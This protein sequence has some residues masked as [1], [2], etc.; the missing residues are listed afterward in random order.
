MYLSQLH[1]SPTD[2][3][4]QRTLHDVYLLHQ[5]L[6]AAFP[7]EA[8]QSGGRLLYRLEPSGGT[9]PNVRLLVQSEMQPQW[10]RIEVGSQLSITAQHTKVFDPELAPGS[11]FRFRIRA[12]PTVKREGRRLGVIGEKDQL[13]WLQRKLAAS[14]CKLLDCTV[15]DEGHLTGRK[16]AR[17]SG[18]RPYVMTFRSSRFEGV[19][20][21]E[22]T[23]DAVAAIGAGLGPGKA[24]G[25]GMLSLARL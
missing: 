4:T 3:K 11:L 24:F 18:V 1:L 23:S 9:E 13:D 10:G 12:N 14:G 2:K 21:V 6:L 25:F 22:S 8:H 19:L 5:V 7:R 15:H 16:S 17:R 20:R